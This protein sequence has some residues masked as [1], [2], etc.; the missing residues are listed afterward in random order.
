[1]AYG[2]VIAYDEVLFE[3]TSAF[4]TVGLTTGITPGLSEASRVL[5]ILL[6]Y[7]GRIG[8]MSITTM[9]KSHNIQLWHYVEENI[10]IG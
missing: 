2:N 7:L 1:M 4:A 10:P 3:T 5:L 6:M 9:L 8:P